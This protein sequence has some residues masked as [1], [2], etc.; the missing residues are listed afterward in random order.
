M[1]CIIGSVDIIWL[2]TSVIVLCQG[3]TKALDIWAVARYI[4]TISTQS[5]VWASMLGTM[6]VLTFV[7]NNAYT[8]CQELTL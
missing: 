7:T 2:V 5:Q 4:Y 1:V 6:V 8:R 3:Y